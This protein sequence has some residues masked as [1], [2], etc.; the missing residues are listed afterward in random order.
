MFLY[1]IHLLFLCPSIMG[2]VEELSSYIPSLSSLELVHSKDK[3]PRHKC[4]NAVLA[5][6]S[7]QTFILG[8]LNDVS[9]TYDSTQKSQ[10]SAVH[11][12]LKEKGHYFKDKN[13]LVLDREDRWFE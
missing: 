11:L 12:H 7:A 10:D 3:T 8:R 6:R 13:V 1:G 5:V 4:N 9:A 2:K